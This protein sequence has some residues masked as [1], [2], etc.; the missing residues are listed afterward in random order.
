LTSGEAFVYSGR[1]IARPAPNRVAI[2]RVTKATRN[3]EAFRMGIAN[4]TEKRWRPDSRSPGLLS[5][6]APL[7]RLKDLLLGWLRQAN[8]NLL[9]YRT[10]PLCYES[11][12]RRLRISTF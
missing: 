9:P 3:V 1:R 7:Q 8:G 12:A 5:D 6:A 2:V 11:S 4:H 10:D